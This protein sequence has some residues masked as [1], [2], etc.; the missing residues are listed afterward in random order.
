MKSV[1]VVDPGERTIDNVITQSAVIHM[2]EECAG[3]YWFESWGRKKLSE[4]GLPLMK[5][6]RV[7]KVCDFFLVLSV[8]LHILIVASFAYSF[9]VLQF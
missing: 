2:L 6:S 7:V 3:L 1:P 4:I 5:S 8:K 9:S